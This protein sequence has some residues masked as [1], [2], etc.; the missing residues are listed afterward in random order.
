MVSYVYQ[1]YVV[2]FWATSGLHLRGYLVLIGKK[3]DYTESCFLWLVLRRYSISS[4]QHV[5]FAHFSAST[6]VTHS[7]GIYLKNLWFKLPDEYQMSIIQGRCDIVFLKQQ[8]HRMPWWN[9]CRSGWFQNNDLLTCIQIEPHWLSVVPA[10][11]LQ[12]AWL[13]MEFGSVA[14]G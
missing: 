10:L 4:Y 3:N 9:K 14:V 13:H 12:M 1:L 8:V 2:S 5:S 11:G 7:F 6:W